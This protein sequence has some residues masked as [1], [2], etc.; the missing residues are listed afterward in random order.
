MTF[1]A[2][3]HPTGKPEVLFVIRAATRL[4]D[5]VVDLQQPKNVL[6]LALTIP[7]AVAGLS[8]NARPEFI[9]NAMGAHASKDPRNPRRTASRK[10]WAFRSNP[11]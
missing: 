2:I 3:A 6:L 7:T 1:E 8:T 4:R 11:S 9:C 10:A 5:N